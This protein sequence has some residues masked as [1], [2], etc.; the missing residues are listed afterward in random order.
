MTRPSGQSCANCDYYVT[1]QG[2]CCRYG[3]TDISGI[4]PWPVVDKNDWC[5]LWNVTPASLIVAG[6]QGDVGPMGPQGPGGP[7]G[8][9]GAD[10]P[11]WN[12]SVSGAL[13]SGGNNG[14]F[15]IRQDSGTITLYLKQ[16]GTWA[17]MMS[18]ATP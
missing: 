16:N 7:V 10:A 14:D 6:P 17:S 1:P 5:P 3:P 15:W 8:A 4:G 18:W 11:H 2:E 12:A 9:S 13:P